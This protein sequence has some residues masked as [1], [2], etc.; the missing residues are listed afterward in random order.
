MLF[1]RLY[2]YTP[3]ECRCLQRSVRTLDPLEL[4]LQLVVSHLLWVLG[5]KLG[6]SGRKEELSTTAPRLQ[7]QLKVVS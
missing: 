6:S 2:L 5:T 7:L 4:E 1:M 3:Y